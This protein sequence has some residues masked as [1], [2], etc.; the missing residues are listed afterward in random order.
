MQLRPS[1]RVAIVDEWNE[2]IRLCNRFK[3]V[4]TREQQEE[5]LKFM[6]LMNSSGTATL[7]ESEIQEAKG[8][9]TERHAAV[10]AWDGE[11]YKF[12]DSEGYGHGNGSKIEIGKYIS[13]IFKRP[14]IMGLFSEEM[15]DEFSKIRSWVALVEKKKQLAELNGEAPS[16]GSNY[17]KLYS[18]SKSYSPA[19]KPSHH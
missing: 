13:Y 10:Q 12:F 19:R 14:R 5:I 8:F 9:I 2:Y 16:S 3:H 7:C 6:L 17:P 11:D 1:V 15:R 4:P 18:S